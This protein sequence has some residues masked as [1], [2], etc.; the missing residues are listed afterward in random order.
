VIGCSNNYQGTF[1]GRSY[2]ICTK[3]SLSSSLLANVKERNEDINHKCIIEC[4]GASR[5]AQRKVLQQYGHYEVVAANLYT[6]RYKI[7]RID[8]HSFVPLWQS[9]WRHRVDAY[10]RLSD[11]LDD[12]VFEQ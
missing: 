9:F 10:G 2:L 11:L 6:R 8:I 3:P 1:R 12:K 7:E 5:S 4:L